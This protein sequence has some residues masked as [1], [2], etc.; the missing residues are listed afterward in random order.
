MKRYTR[1]L[2]LA[3]VAAAALTTSVAGAADAIAINNATVLPTGP[4]P[5]SSGKAFVNV[6]GR[7]VPDALTFASY[8]VLEFDSSD[9]QITNTVIRV[10]S[11]IVTLT[12][13]L[14]GFS[15]RGRMAF[16]VTTDLTTDIE[17]NEV[18]PACFFDFAEPNGLNGQFATTYLLG[19]REFVPVRTGTVEKF[20]FQIAN[21]SAVEMYL[22]NQ[23]NTGG[24]IR[25]IIAPEFS[26]QDSELAAGT[27]A[28]YT[29]SVPAYAPRLTARTRTFGP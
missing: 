13:T 14:A 19:T 28:G 15:S 17:P 1:P 9:F 22:K 18:N 8:A 11:L 29:H 3:F 6:E 10:P 27:Y 7:E 26:N 16:Y 4:R 5:G 2:A 24:N 21:A 20:A 23:I 25:I 12:Q